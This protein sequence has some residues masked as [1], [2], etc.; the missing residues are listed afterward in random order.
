MATVGKALRAKR[1]ELGLTLEDMHAK[2]KVG[3]KF[4][5]AIEN[6]EYE[7]LPPE[8]YTIGF[9][10]S[11]ADAVGLDPGTVIAQYKREAKAGI[12]P[13]TAA[14]EDTL[15]D[16]DMVKKPISTWLIVAILAVLAIAAFGYY[17]WLRSTPEPGNPGL[18]TKS[19]GATATSTIK[20]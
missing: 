15:A 18:G 6:E 14:G 3:L 7:F 19:Q 5:A 8:S 2:T 16:R 10:R 12:E 20:P 4:L 9:I 13:S 1:E 17:G 11:Y